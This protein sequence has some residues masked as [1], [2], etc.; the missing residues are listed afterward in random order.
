[1]AGLLISLGL[2]VGIVLLTGAFSLRKNKTVK[3]EIIQAGKPL[4]DSEELY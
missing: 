2:C 1:M 3:D 4:L